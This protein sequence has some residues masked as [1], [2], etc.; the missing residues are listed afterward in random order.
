[1]PLFIKDSAIVKVN[2]KIVSIVQL[3]QIAPLCFKD[4]AIVTGTV[5]I[6]K[7]KIVSIVQLYA[8]GT[9]IT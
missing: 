1:M 5:G 7:E 4:N 8:I 6:V 3:K 9:S 2:E